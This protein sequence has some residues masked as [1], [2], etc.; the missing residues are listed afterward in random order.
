VG[1]LVGVIT[2][3]VIAN[4]WWLAVHRPGLPFDL[5]EAGY[6][7]RAVRDSDALHA[8]GL[9]QL[10][11][12][13]RQ[14]DPQAPLVTVT[15]GF[16]RFLTGAGPYRLLGVEQLFAVVLAVATYVAAARL[17]SRRWAVLSAVV[18]L[19]LPG[20]V[21][22]G[23]E[24]EFVL[25]AAALVTAALAA[26]LGAGDFHSTP[27]ALWWGV[28][29]GLAALTRTMVLG[30]VAALLVAAA[31]RLVATRPA[32][33]QILNAGGGV[34]VGFVVAATWYSATWRTVAHY[35]TS[36]G[37]GPAAAGY[38]PARPVW[39]LQWWTERFTRTVHNEI[40]FPLTLALVVCIGL[41]VVGIVGRR[42]A[43][44]R[45][46][47]DR[48]ARGEVWRGRLDGDPMTVAMFVIVSYLVLSSTR[49]VGSGFEL[50]LV[51]AAVLLIMTAASRAGRAAWPIA[52][53]VCT[54]A[55]V[56]AFA[57][58]SGVVPGSRSVT[59][60]VSLGQVSMQVLDSRGPLMRYAQVIFGG[61][62]SIVTCMHV[63]PPATDVTYLTRW[64]AAADAGAG[65]IHTDAVGRDRDPV[66][67]FSVQD[68]F[69]NTNSVDLAYQLTFHQALPT[70]LLLPPSQAGLSLVRQ[71]EAPQLGQP[72]LVVVGPPS[73][74]ARSRAFSPLTDPV[75]VRRALRADGF[76][77]IGRLTLPDGR[78][79][80][81]WWK[82][83]GPAIPTVPTRPSPPS[84]PAPASQSLRSFTGA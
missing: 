48:Q 50:S 46:P 68:P 61:C 62:P 20:V 1:A 15:A 32:R 56:F 74:V 47:V 24:F 36:Y 40:F 7:Q 26:Q 18:V 84:P 54:A 31:V 45:A 13:A 52:L 73:A 27:R 64:L 17:A 72:N 53:T 59:R 69:F 78:V 41:G 10:L 9:I 21:D 14:P 80:Q 28:L 67:F 38:G 81:L 75:I 22:G 34:L 44:A 6:L 35:L 76:S 11:H 63:R 55:A 65:L 71:L 19:A 25:P 57:A 29:L 30:F 39:S 2:L 79:M 16:A 42:R 3:T 83:R 4:L 33:R 37:Y 60:S 66:V 82:P 70:G 77:Q 5:D 12:V 8:G 23:R 51:P 49:N 58:E 43:G